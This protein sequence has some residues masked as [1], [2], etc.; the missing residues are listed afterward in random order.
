MANQ[1]VITLEDPAGLLITPE[2]LEQIGVSIGDQIEISVSE[3]KLIVRPLAVAET[4]RRKAATLKGDEAVDNESTVTFRE[5]IHKELRAMGV[6][7][8]ARVEVT[9]ADGRKLLFHHEGDPQLDEVVKRAD[10]RE[11][12][13]LSSGK[14]YGPERARK[15]DAATR[16]IFDRRRD[17]YLRLAEGP[18]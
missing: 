17:A 18:E 16:D 5:L 13:I 6:S 14:A 15:I 8:A 3:R 7:S 12:R 1:H 2:M 4:E 10:V 11:V 9:F